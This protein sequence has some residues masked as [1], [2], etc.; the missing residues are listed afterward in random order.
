M[1]ESISD[2]NPEEDITSLQ[3]KVILI[4]GGMLSSSMMPIDLGH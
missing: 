2:F 4:T 1:T 3:G